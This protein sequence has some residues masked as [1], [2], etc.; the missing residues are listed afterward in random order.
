M[1]RVQSWNSLF[2]IKVTTSLSPRSGFENTYSVNFFDQQRKL[3][4]NCTMDKVMSISI[5]LIVF[6]GL[7]ILFFT[8]HYYLK[9]ET[10][11]KEEKRRELLQDSC[12]SI[13][14]TP[15]GDGRL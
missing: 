9:K 11:K 2:D 13:R 1:S 14:W 5:V 7:L 12:N 10:M 15:I 4:N 8:L 3:R 6:A